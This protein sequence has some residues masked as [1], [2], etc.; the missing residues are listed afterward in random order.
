MYGLLRYFSQYV[1]THCMEREDFNQLSSE[2]WVKAAI[3]A[4]ERG[5]V[6]AV[7]I[8][9]LAES[10]GVSRGSFY[11]HF[12]DRNALL[13]DVLILWSQAQ[14]DDIIDA[15]EREGGPASVRLLR[16]LETCARDTG[17]LEMALRAWAQTD[18]M[19]RN[20]VA[21][22][23][24]K[25]ID[26]LTSLIAESSQTSEDATAKARVAYAAWLGEYT[27]G[28]PVGEETRVANMRC[29]HQMLLRV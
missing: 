1:N 16:L 10:L 25:R 22:V 8:V 20:M 21:D 17:H 15:V 9:P 2:N 5:G 6:D 19:A 14:S 29:L 11:W 18:A 27:A 7:R 13:R 23:D 26:Y 24:R 12:K 4:F 28:A 3:A